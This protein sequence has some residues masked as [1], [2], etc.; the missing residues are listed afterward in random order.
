MSIIYL[1][2]TI[3]IIFVAGPTWAQTAVPSVIIPQS[4][5]VHLEDAGKRVH[6]NTLILQLGN[7]KVTP[8]DLF[9]ATPQLPPFPGFNYETPAS[10]ACLYGLVKATAGCN[11]RTLKTNATTGSKVVAIVNAY[12]A[13]TV[14]SDLKKYSRQFGLPAINSAN[15]QVIYA[16]G[17]RPPYDQ[18]WAQESGLDVEMVHA[19]APMA[20]I[21]LVE[22]ASNSFADML[23]AETVAAK[24]V[25]AAGGGEISNSWGGEEFPDEMTPA[26][27]APFT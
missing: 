17:T 13:P 22:A 27:T 23:Q 19:L 25:A 18:G 6:T 26:Y 24:A 15:F 5:V 11:P 12:D 16:A 1:L 14:L 9:G 3:L 20:K 21:I 8:P 2:L 7:P 10:L 4:S